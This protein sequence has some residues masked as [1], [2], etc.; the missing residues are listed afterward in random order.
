ML[1]SFS[2]LLVFFLDI[3][4]SNYIYYSLRDLEIY[5][6]SDEVSDY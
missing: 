2:I 5:G 6:K 1:W 3:H 4:L